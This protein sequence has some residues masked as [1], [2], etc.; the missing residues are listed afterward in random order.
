[1]SLVEGTNCGFV[2]VAPTTDPLGSIHDVDTKAWSGKFQ[3]PAGAAH[4]SEVGWYCDTATEAADTEVGL[5]AHDAVNNRPGTLLGKTV[6]AKGTTA[7]WKKAAV[8]IDVT[9]STWY[10]IAAQCDDTAT[11]TYCNYQNDA[12]QKYDWKTSQITLPSPWGS[13]YGTAARFEALYALYEEGGEL[14]EAAGT[15]SASSG[16]T[17]LCSVLRKVAGL[18]SGISNIASAIAKR[19]VSAAS[20]VS[21]FSSAVCVLSQMFRK[22]SGLCSAVSF[23]IGSVASLSVLYFDT[24]LSWVHEDGSF[25]LLFIGRPQKSSRSFYGGPWSYFLKIP[26]SSA[27]PPA[28]PYVISL[29]VEIR[30]KQL[31]FFKFVIVRSDGRV[32]SPFFCRYVVP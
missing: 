28:S 8:D 14:V 11:V 7:G 16:A 17:G 6:F 19:S 12:G 25:L 30:S 20:I 24:S 18:S 1:M 23:A 22:V 3:S 2:L 9:E 5:Y 4:V 15:S 27:S 10:W 29:P 21:A 31:Y 32:S 13:S 26:G